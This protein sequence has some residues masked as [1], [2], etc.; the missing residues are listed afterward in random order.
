[1][2]GHDLVANVPTYRL[3]KHLEGLCPYQWRSGLKHD[4]SS[5][6][7]LVPV[8]Q[9]R[10]RN[11]LGEE[12]A[13]EPDYVFPL[14]K[15]SDLANGRI[16]PARFVLVTQSRVGD[17]TAQIEARAPRTWH[18]LSSHRARFEARKSCIYSA[19]VPFALFGIGDYSYAPW[20]VAVSG[21]HR[22]P[23]FALVGPF[24]GKPVM[25][26]DTCYY[27]PFQSEAE[28]EITVEVL[29]S[30]P[31]LEFLAALTFQDSK[32]PITAELLQRLNLKAIALDAG[33]ADAWAQAR[34]HRL[35]YAPGDRPSLQA[36][37]MMER[38]E[39]DV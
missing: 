32:R 4:C 36:E 37:F 8:G 33:L 1:L 5:V 22:T 30:A 27:L 24:D 11:K 2:V 38:P 13:L 35:A 15:C 6:M 9:D 17:E 16:A 25:F 14:L 7:E 20:K 28:A 3:L 29:N 23:H 19:G 21:L 26:D 39:S 31:C 18:Y 12:I 34:N 10:F